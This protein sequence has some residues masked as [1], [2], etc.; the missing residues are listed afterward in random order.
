MKKDSGQDLREQG[1]T[2]P[3]I[4]T[5]VK[6]SRMY[7]YLLLRGISRKKVRQL[8]LEQKAQQAPPPPV[9]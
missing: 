8:W 1:Y 4:A 9:R 3:Q 6:I 5:E 7:V 2:V